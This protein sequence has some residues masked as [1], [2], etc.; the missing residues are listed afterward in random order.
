MKL[1]QFEHRKAYQFILTFENG[2]VWTADLENLI[3]RHVEVDS[4][5]TAR[6]DPDWGC[7]EFLNGRVDVEPKTLY[8]HVCA[9]AEQRAA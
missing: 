8:R 2:E 5:G 4:V 7:L 6:I 1:T 9:A 3:G